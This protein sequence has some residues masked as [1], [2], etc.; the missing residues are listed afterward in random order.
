MNVALKEIIKLLE[1]L[2]VVGCCGSAVV[3]LLS[4]IQDVASIMHHEEEPGPHTVQVE[5][6]G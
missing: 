4:G 2:F 3:I 1:L 5:R 6:Q